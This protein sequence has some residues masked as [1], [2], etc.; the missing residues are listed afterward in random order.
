MKKILVFDDEEAIRMLYELE[1]SEEG[2]EVICSGEA[3][4]C[5]ELIWDHRPNVVVMDKKMGTHDGLEVLRNIRD[6][7]PA[8]PL[9]LCT[10]YPSHDSEKG[11]KVADFYAAK[12]SDL[13]ELK[14][15]V[16]AAME[17]RRAT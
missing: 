6:R 12:S 10:A 16:K 7:F 5:M 8:L 9:V 2:Y 11:D 14:V 17:L 3:S 4:R 1:L 15:K 13:E